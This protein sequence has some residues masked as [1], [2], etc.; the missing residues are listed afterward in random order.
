[1][2]ARVGVVALLT[3][4]GRGRL[5]AALPHAMIC[6]SCLEAER[7]LRSDNCAA[8]IL[9]PCVP[10]VTAE[11]AQGLRSEFPLI[12]FVLYAELDPL[13]FARMAELMRNGFADVVLRGYDDTPSRITQLL[14][15]AIARSRDQRT[16]ERVIEQFGGAPAALR[17][18]IVQMFSHPNRF[19]N[20]H[21]LA[22]IALMSIRAVFRHLD[23]AGVSSGRRLVAAARVLRAYQL[24]RQ[25][26]PTSRE[27][28]RRLGYA[29]ADQM[30]VHFTEL[31]GYTPAQ[32]KKGVEETDFV[33]RVIASICTRTADAALAAAELSV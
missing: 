12:A 8:L 9:D 31:T 1:M 25:H 6:G 17:S 5:L 15:D 32:V 22:R 30:C 21:D 24:L 10:G 7:Q 13:A 16:V 27:V 33:D 26:S 23:A 29:S 19:H 28:A 4:R 18:A 11:W 3:D 20:V 2:H 14:E